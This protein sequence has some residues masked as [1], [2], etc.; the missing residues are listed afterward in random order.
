MK[1][2]TVIT[3]SLNWEKEDTID[4][5]RCLATILFMLVLF[6]ITLI[7]SLVIG[8]RIVYN[9]IRGRNLD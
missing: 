8:I 6:P 3:E 2:E 5:V 9:T 7:I 4:L 1:K